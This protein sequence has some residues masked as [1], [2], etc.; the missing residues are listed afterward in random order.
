[1]PLFESC[2]LTNSIPKY[3]KFNFLSNYTFERVDQISIIINIMVTKKQIKALKI[4]EI[5]INKIML[6]K[7]N[8]N[9]SK[10]SYDDSLLV[11]Q[12]PY[13]GVKNLLKKTLYPYIFRIDTFFKGENQ[14]KL[15]LFH[16]FLERIDEKILGL[17]NNVGGDWFE[18]KDIDYKCIIEYE[19]KDYE[20]NYIK[21]PIDINYV[22]DID[23]LEKMNLTDQ[24]RFI[25]TVPNLWIEGSRF[26]LTYCIQKYMIRREEK[27]ENEYLFNSDSEYETKNITDLET[28]KEA[29]STYDTE[30][31]DI[32]EGENSG[33]VTKVPEE[34]VVKKDP[35][36]GWNKIFEK[37][38]KEGQEK[39]KK[40]GKDGGKRKNND[41]EKSLD[42]KGE[43]EGEKNINSLNISS[44][45]QNQF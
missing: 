31:I 39:K 12:T 1:M 10:L 25:V 23:D 30:G 36:E 16:S 40:R 32:K 24:V 45:R 37:K 42:K 5:D 43:D 38:G 34:V 19:G 7:K 27:T 11:F 9:K 29:W 44:L 14:E 4:S 13:M 3:I 33:N 17:V 35:F 26:G 21:W 6:G 20:N 15:K 2:C 18:S 41:V 22:K 28:E 8:G